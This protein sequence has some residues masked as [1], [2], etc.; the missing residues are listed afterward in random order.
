MTS[1]TV[2]TGRILTP[3][4]ARTRF[5]AKT[6]N[7]RAWVV[8]PASLTLAVLV[9]IAFS[10][11][12]LFQGSARQEWAAGVIPSVWF[13]AFWQAG[14]VAMIILLAVLIAGRLPLTS[15]TARVACFA[16]ALLTSACL[17]E[18]IV[19]WIQWGA[20]PTASFEA[21]L[22]RAFRWIP[23]A[24]VGAAILVGRQRA[25]E[26][27]NRLH[28]AEIQRL[29]LEKQQTA[30]QL[31]QLQSQ[32][33]P[34]FL[35]NTLATIRR[36]QT[37][38]PCRGRETLTGFV[39]YLKAS[40]PGMR[41]PETTLGRELDLVTA[42]L[43]V[44]RVRMG[45]RLNFRID[46]EQSLRECRIPPFSVATLVEN[47]VKHGLAGLPAGGQI[48]VSARADG[49][50]LE[51]AVADTGQGLAAASG[52][53]T[54]L[55]NLRARLRSLYGEDGKLVLAT[56]H[57]SGLVSSLQVPLHRPDPEVGPVA[58]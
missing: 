37:T 39:A 9:C 16:A 55:A 8:T 23:V 47:A 26:L 21:I 11:Q 20:W 12:F 27:A 41:D 33:E 46:V 54:G 53:G 22:P 38:D 7:D 56:N 36:L 51:V 50:R 17:G 32:I 4:P 57:P 1:T 30:L 44:L 15:T 19:L 24:S 34:H 6:R 5:V 45:E 29:Q 2:S 42:Y 25:R 10:T 48:V 18:W 49:G 13:G 43:D 58:A 52:T 14:L 31:Q 35:F 28:R 3:V 40:L